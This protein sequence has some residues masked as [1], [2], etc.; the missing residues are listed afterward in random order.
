MWVLTCKLCLPPSDRERAVVAIVA[1][2]GCAPKGPIAADPEA[3]EFCTFSRPLTS[4]LCLFFGVMRLEN[5]GCSMKARPVFSKQRF[6]L[7]A[8]VFFGVSV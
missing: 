7:P 5:V 4:F 2:Q 6:S 8:L 1:G 3:E